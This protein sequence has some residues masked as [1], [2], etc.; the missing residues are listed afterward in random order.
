MGH[1]TYELGG[2]R[3]EYDVLYN[4]IC[5]TKFFIVPSIIYIFQVCKEI[6]LTLPESFY[7]L[8]KDVQVFNAIYH[9]SKSWDII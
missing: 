6:S 2:W 9:I 5:I 8:N 1:R 7:P 4:Y 3:G